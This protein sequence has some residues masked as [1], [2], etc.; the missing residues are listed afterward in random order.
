MRST[1]IVVV[2]ILAI[3]I[4]G[5]F[6]ISGI[7]KSQPQND[8]FQNQS[9]PTSPPSVLI[10]PHHLAAEEYIKTSLKKVAD[11]RAEK[12]ATTKHIILFGPNHFF[13]GHAKVIAEKKILQLR[14]DDKLIDALLKQNL[15]ELEPGIIQ[16]DHAIT[17][18]LPFIQK[19][20]PQAKIT[21][22]LMREPMKQEETQLLANFFASQTK[23]QDT[24][25]I[26]SI[27]FS[28]YKPKV[29]ADIN[30]TQTMIALEKRDIDFFQK[31]VDADS[32]HIL[33][34]LMQYAYLKNEFFTM[35]AHTN[36][37]T[38]LGNPNEQS[39]TSHIMGYLSER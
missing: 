20:F 22:L 10:I 7:K 31:K 2:A 26:A 33:M 28:H 34:M 24:L 36:S 32:P 17:A 37:A 21:P 19:Q 38:L 5:F 25:L 27:D 4:G 13:R 30:D 3:L 18:P 35:L 23:P 8:N 12:G 15:A 29:T 16:Q 9:L 1:L 14:Q 6:A 39:T 11:L